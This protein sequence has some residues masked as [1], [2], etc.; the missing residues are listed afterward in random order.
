MTETVTFMTFD[1][2]QHECSPVSHAY[3]NDNLT[4]TSMYYLDIYIYGLLT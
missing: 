1:K 4:K 3:N 2:L